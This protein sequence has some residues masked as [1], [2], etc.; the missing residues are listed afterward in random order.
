MKARIKETGEIVDVKFSVHPN[1]AVEETYW[2]CK[3]KQES[4]HKWELDFGGVNILGDFVDW[5]QRRY[6]IAKDIVAYSFS[7]P[8]HGVSMVSYIHSCVE[9]ADMLIEELKK[10]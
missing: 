9:V 5:E 6:E 7:T 2:W 10:K 8:M 3:D 4:Y 1:P